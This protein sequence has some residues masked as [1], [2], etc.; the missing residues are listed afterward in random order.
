MNV[1]IYSRQ[2]ALDLKFYNVCLFICIIDR[3][4]EEHSFI[5]KPSM[6]WR[7]FKA[8]TDSNLGRRRTSTRAARSS[9]HPSSNIEWRYSDPPAVQYAVLVSCRCN[10]TGMKPETT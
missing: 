2:L 10:Y 7:D 8:E 5:L 3:R 6:L 9:Q 4:D 1:Q